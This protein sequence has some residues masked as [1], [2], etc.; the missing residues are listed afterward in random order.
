[1]SGL[2][3]ISGGA[4]ADGLAVVGAF[5][6]GPEDLTPPG[7]GTLILFG[8]G[9]PE[10]WDAF[11][12]SAECGDGAPHPMDRWSRR[13]IT[14]LAERFDAEALFPF[15]GPPF[16]P[17]Q[18][19]AARGEAARTSPVAMQ[20]TSGRGLWAS[21]RGALSLSAAIELPERPDADPCAQCAAPCL[22]ACPVG[23]FSDGRY[24]VPRCIAHVKSDAGT[25]CHAGCLVRR[26]CPAGA[27]LDLP[28]TQRSF[29]LQAFVRANG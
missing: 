9:G 4:A 20:V 23:A 14:A 2:D 24:D 11:Q 1:M 26:S 25:A 19:W 21:Y 12:R 29:H 15:G 7:C 22:T 13:V 3:D 6:P 18:R 8:P 10:M 27:A 16:A 17:F 28:A 5:H